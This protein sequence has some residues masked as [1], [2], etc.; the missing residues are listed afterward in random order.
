[1][2]IV[3]IS[4]IYFNQFQTAENWIS[5]FRSPQQYTYSISN[6]TISLYNSLSF[7]QNTGN[8][9]FSAT[10]G[11]I[12]I[13]RIDNVS[14]ITR[15]NYTGF[16]LTAANLFDY[17]SN[18]VPFADFKALQYQPRCYNNNSSL[19]FQGPFTFTI[20]RFWPELRLLDQSGY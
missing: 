2:A 1:M 11:E 10:Q 14:K 19:A 18:S 16:T 5:I 3:R 13:F 6:L 8:W 20:N 17:N 15:Y 9:G 12:R 7:I 4:G